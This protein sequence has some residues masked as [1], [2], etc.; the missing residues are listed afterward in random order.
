MKEKLPYRDLC[1]GRYL[2]ACV[3]RW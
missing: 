3:P 2:L 1:L